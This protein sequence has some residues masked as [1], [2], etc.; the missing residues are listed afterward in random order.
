MIK[1]LSIDTKKRDEMIDITR[2]VQDIINR[3]GM[4][5]GL[6]VVQSLH[7]TAGIT[8][9]ENAD[10][11]VKTDFI[12][13]LDELYPWHHSSDLH[14]EGNTAAHLKTSTVGH[15]QTVIVSDGELLLGTWQGIYLCEFDGPRSGRKVSVKTIQS[16]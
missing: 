13:R 9:N 12:R 16:E 5:E 7:T 1:T 6:V 3:S 15:S 8:V 10:P 4:T 11:D 14:G 2:Y